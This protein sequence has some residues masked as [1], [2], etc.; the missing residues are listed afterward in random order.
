MWLAIGGAGC[1]SQPAIKLV[2]SPMRVAF[3]VIRILVSVT[4][5][6][7]NMV[8]LIVIELAQLS[9]LSANGTSNALEAPFSGPPI[10]SS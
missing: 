5:P 8:L 2:N 4:A 10:I 1:G 3:V 9:W 7:S 6:T